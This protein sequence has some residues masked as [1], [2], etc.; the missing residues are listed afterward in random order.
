MSSRVTTYFCI[1]GQC[2]RQS[3]SGKIEEEREV[4]TIHPYKGERREGYLSIAIHTTQTI[5]IFQ[6][7]I[8][9]LLSMGLP[10]NT[11]KTLSDPYNKKVE[12]SIRLFPPVFLLPQKSLLSSLL[13]PFLWAPEKALLLTQSQGSHFHHL[14]YIRFLGGLLQTCP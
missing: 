1:V 9:Y 7:S 2:H 14:C 13:S 6:K 10:T 8:K 3:H 5:G 12:A 11:D 4:E